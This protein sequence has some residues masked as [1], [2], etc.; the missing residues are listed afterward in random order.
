MNLQKHAQPPETMR[1]LGLFAGLVSDEVPVPSID[2]SSSQSS[3]EPKKESRSKQA[4]LA[5]EKR[6]KALNKIF[7]ETMTYFASMLFVD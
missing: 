2:F 7:Y 1:N 4:L 5:K 6:Q 3:D